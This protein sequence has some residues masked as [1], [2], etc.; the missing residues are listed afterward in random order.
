MCGRYRRTTSEDE[1]AHRYGIEIPRERDLPISW[2]IA[3]TQDKANEPYR[4]RRSRTDKLANVLRLPSRLFGRSTEDR[5]ICCDIFFWR[6][7]S[8]AQRPHG[9][10]PE[11][12]ERGYAVEDI[13]VYCSSYWAAPLKHYAL[14][15]ARC[16][17]TS[18][19]NR[20]FPDVRRKVICV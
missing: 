20:P 14:I 2:N 15:G 9:K 12:Q 1:L 11:A 7:R 5:K 18:S 4:A 17:L 6:E 16:R 19:A 13:N 8:K 10:R 3:P